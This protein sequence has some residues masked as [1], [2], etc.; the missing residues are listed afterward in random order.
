MKLSHLEQITDY[1][2][3]FKKISAAFRVSDSIIKIVFDKNDALYFNMQRSNSSIFKCE[4]YPRSKVYN[5]PFD[6]ILANDSTV[7]TSYMQNCSMMI[8][9]YALKPL[10][11]LLIKKKQPTCR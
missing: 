7:Q 10:W 2:Q 11:L 1:L 5:A 3:N 4:E 6:V 9:L 8:K